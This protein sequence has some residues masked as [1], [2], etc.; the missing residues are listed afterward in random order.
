MDAQVQNNADSQGVSIQEAFWIWL[1]VAALSFGAP[2]G[3]IA[4]MHRI[5]VE[6]KCWSS[7]SRFCMRSTT[8]CFPRPRG[9][10]MGHLNRMAHA[11]NTRPLL[12]WR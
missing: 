5:L 7:E 12:S 2:A 3:Q 8:A 10:E 11:S 6:E 4:V 9:A 1:R